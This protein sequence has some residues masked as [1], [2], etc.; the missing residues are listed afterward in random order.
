MLKTISI[1]EITGEDSQ[2][3]VLENFSNNLRSL[4]SAIS[5]SVSGSSR[6]TCGGG[7]FSLVKFIIKLNNNEQLSCILD[8]PSDGSNGITAKWLM[9]GT[10]SEIT[11]K[12]RKLAKYAYRIQKFCVDAG[13]SVR[14]VLTRREVNIEDLYSAGNYRILPVMKKYLS[15]LQCSRI[16][17]ILTP[18]DQHYALV[19]KVGSLSFEKNS[20]ICFLEEKCLSA[21][22]SATNELRDG[23]RSADQSKIRS[24]IENQLGLITNTPLRNKIEV[25]TEMVKE[26]ITYKDAP[27][28][29]E[30]YIGYLPKVLL[31]IDKIIR[32]ESIQSLIP[33]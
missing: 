21:N 20:P 6:N 11:T 5:L 17:L 13:M 4:I 26:M 12:Y 29:P 24:D 22:S 25:L 16:D 15:G 32:H 28:S 8:L 2:V 27:V 31:S 7:I 10:E 1:P 30:L 19:K 18:M 14:I 9:H 3:E 33:S 23:R